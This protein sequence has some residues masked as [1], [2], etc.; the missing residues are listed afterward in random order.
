MKPKDTR[1]KGDNPPAR[2]TS[3]Q[4]TEQLFQSTHLA[5]PAERI[6]ENQT[7]YYLSG[8]ESGTGE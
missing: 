2:V 1:P 6:S 8:G 7:F 3:A 5:K 4:I